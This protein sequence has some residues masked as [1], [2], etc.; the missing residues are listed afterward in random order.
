MIDAARLK[1]E[2]APYF[3]VFTDGIIP[4]SYRLKALPRL[5]RG[6]GIAEDHPILSMAPPASV[7]PVGIAEM[8][9]T[10]GDAERRADLRAM[11]NGQAS[12]EELRRGVGGGSMRARDSSSVIPL[13]EMRLSISNDEEYM[14]T[15]Q[16]VATAW[17]CPRPPISD[18]PFLLLPVLPVISKL[19]RGRFCR[20]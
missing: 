5:L 12:G 6:S 11:D 8:S 1:V 13:V 4:D 9:T 2:P 19:T 16:V 7:N 10:S 20:L 18:V 14:E 3:H 17:L 15:I